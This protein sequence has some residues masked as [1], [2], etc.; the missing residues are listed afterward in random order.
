[1]YDQLLKAI[2]IEERH[3]PELDVQQ[4]I[5]SHRSMS[6]QEPQCCDG[7]IVSDAAGP[8]A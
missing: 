1:M 3:G 5:G 6:E 2:S 7:A 4:S 8:V